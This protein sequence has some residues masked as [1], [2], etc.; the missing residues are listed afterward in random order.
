MASLM[1][2]YRLHGLIFSLLIVA[3]LFIW[4]NSASLVPPAETR[5]DAAPVILGRDSAAGFVN[6]LRRGI[7]PAELINAC[8]AEW[9]KSSTR[10]AAVSPEQRREV[11]QLVQQHAALEPRR[12][13]PVETYRLITQILKRRK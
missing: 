4:K 2:R 6:L 9:K 11:E 12:R 5:T 3:G 7:S 1:R 8:F 13:N 10:L